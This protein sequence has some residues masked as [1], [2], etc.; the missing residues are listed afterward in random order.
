MCI[1]DSYICRSFPDCPIDLFASVDLD[2]P[3]PMEIYDRWAQQLC[4]QYFPL[5]PHL[6]LNVW[7]MAL[8]LN[9]CF[10]AHQIP[11]QARWGVAPAKLWARIRDMLSQD[12][13]VI[14]A[15]G[16]NFP[17]PWQK[18]KCGLYKK[19]AEGIFCRVST[20]KAHYVNVTGMDETWAR[21]SSWGQMLFLNRDEYNRYVALH[22]N[23]LFSNILYLE[24]RSSHI[25]WRSDS[26]K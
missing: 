25:T 1:R 18:A 23:A 22:S 21:V 12:L 26:S 19:N 24:K 13:P 3:I 11:L 17:F 9:R 10:K 15:I 7:M 14:L 8:G 20:T 6:G 5:L 4:R 2:E 16:Q